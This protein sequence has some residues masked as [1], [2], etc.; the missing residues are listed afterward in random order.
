MTRY[1]AFPFRGAALVLV[2]S[3]TAGLVLAAHAGLPGIPLAL[4]LLS[5]F[6]KY[7]FILLDAIV[8]GDEEPP[9]LSIEMVN[10]VSE[11]RPLAQALLITAGVML[12]GAV[13]RFAGLALAWSCG[14]LLILA[15]PASIA[16]LGVSGNPFRAAWPPALFALIRGVGRG[17]LLLIC[18]TPG[19]A[20]VIYWMG[21]HG[22]PDYVLLAGAQMLLLVTFAL[23]GGMVHEHRLELGIDT[24]SRRERVAERD[25]REHVSERNRTLERAYMKFRVSKPLEGWQ[26]I[27]AWLTLH[28]RSQDQ[29]EKLLLEHRAVLTAASRW[30]D[31]RPAD[32]LTDDLIALFLARRETGRALEVLEERLDSNPKYRPAQAT[33]AVRLAELAMAAGKRTLRR[34]LDVGGGPAA[35]SDF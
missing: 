6:F 10:P 5:W 32:R 29:G 31:V 23:V 4:I 30:E 7:C 11:Q 2:L 16:V 12:V 26:E 22:A 35:G 20:A 1:L 27:Q 21:R 18:V 17:Y 9:V 28:G 19:S 13:G 14:A 8:A 15:L 33:H 24:R 34:R 25:E 3:F